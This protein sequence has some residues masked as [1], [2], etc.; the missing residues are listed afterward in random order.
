MV[1]SNGTAR[2]LLLFFLL[3]LSG[4]LWSTTTTTTT[5][6]SFVGAAPGAAPEPEGKVFGGIDA[7]YAEFPYFV[8]FPRVIYSLG[9]CGGALIAPDIAL[10]GASCNTPNNRTGQEIIIGGNV[11]R[12]VVECIGH[13]FYVDA[14]KTPYLSRIWNVALCKLDAEVNL[15]ETSAILELD[16]DGDISTNGEL[17]TVLGLGSNGTTYSEVLLKG[18]LFG[19]ECDEAGSVSPIDNY[20][21][22]D[23]DPFSTATCIGDIG[24][25]LIKTVVSTDGGP[26]TH[27]LVGVVAQNSACYEFSSSGVTAFNRFSVLA[28][29]VDRTMCELNSVAAVDCDA[30]PPDEVE[31][32]NADQS[33]FV[34]DFF[35]DAYAHENEWVLELLDDDDDEWQLVAQNSLD[36]G[37][38]FYKDV[39]CLEPDETYRWTVTD[40]YG[41]GL[42]WKYQFD[43]PSGN[44]T[45][46]LNGEE[47][48]ASE[49][50]YDGTS[51]L[52]FEDYVVFVT[53]D[54]P[55]GDIDLLTLSPT[56]APTGAP[57]PSPTC[58]D[59]GL[60]VVNVT[61]VTN[62]H[63]EDNEWTL[64]IDDDE[65][66]WVAIAENSLEE[67]NFRYVD[68]LC[69]EFNRS[70]RFT[71]TDTAG[72]GLRFFN[73]LRLNPA[74][75]FSVAVDGVGVIQD[76]DFDFEVQEVFDTNPLDCSTDDPGFWNFTLP[77]GRVTGRYCGAV[78][79]KIRRSNPGTARFICDIPLTNG[80]TI[81]DKCAATCADVGVGPCA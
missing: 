31:C 12:T 67:P 43:R 7:A 50:D 8:E 35:T 3:L 47:I 71:I 72:D 25:P 37:Y 61:V 36:I 24:G 66:E 28:P 2:R 9:Q 65:D 21:C 75:S 54:M 57:T 39:Y 14:H 6:T 10:T 77:G 30:D 11:T 33:R 62:S 32:A 16:R 23:N 20:I 69:V 55:G 5:T 45:V 17:L 80:G 73:T 18:F 38:F 1:T 15:N 41:D 79:Q 27:Y 13:P 56:S 52:G 58:D 76:R 46:T 49:E 60:A 78:E 68:E 19:D 70:F 64:E 51:S 74:G 22:T 4:D 53:P 48:T 81:A 44:Y 34:V 29:W 40:S 42:T 59:S 26:D 63:P